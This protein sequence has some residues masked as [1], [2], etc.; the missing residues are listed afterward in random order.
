MQGTTLGPNK[1]QSL[2]LATKTANADVAIVNN[3]ATQMQLSPEEIQKLLF[4]PQSYN[5]YGQPFFQQGYNAMGAPMRQMTLPGNFFSS[6]ISL[7]NGGSYICSPNGVVFPP[8]YQV[9]NSP[10]KDAQDTQHGRD[11]ASTARDNSSSAAGGKQGES[12]TH[13]NNEQGEAT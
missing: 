12:K 6:P 10:F 2:V 3:C 5:I 13:D 7:Q 8:N 9:L 1:G 4:H 11:T